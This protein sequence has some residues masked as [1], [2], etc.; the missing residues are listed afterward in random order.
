MK[1]LNSVITFLILAIIGTISLCFVTTASAQP[2]A[3]PWDVN[4]DGVVDIKDLVFVGSHF[5]D[6][7]IT[8][9]DVNGDGLA[10][11]A[12]LI[13]VGVH[14]GEEYKPTKTT[15]NVAADAGETVEMADGAAVDIPPMALSQN[16]SVTI[17]VETDPGIPTEISP[18]KRA[19]G[20]IY[21]IDVGD[22]A[23]HEAIT[24]TLPYDPSRVPTG[25]S[26]E[27]LCLAYWDGNRWVAQESSV[28]TETHEIMAQTN[29]LSGWG[30]WLWSRLNRPKIE[31]F[32]SE[33]EEYSS[34]NRETNGS[35]KEDLTFRAE[36]A[37]GHGIQSA[38][39]QIGLRTYGTLGAAGIS[40]ICLAFGPVPPE[41]TGPCKT[42]LEMSYQDGAYIYLLP[43]SK[44]DYIDANMMTGIDASVTATNTVGEST[45][46]DPIYVP[47]YAP[48]TGVTS[49]NL[50]SPRNNGEASPR[51]TLTWQFSDPESALRFRRVEVAVDSDYNV[52]SGWFRYEVAISNDLLVTSHTIEKDLSKGKT[53]YWA[54]R[55]TD[56]VWDHR[57]IVSLPHR[58]TVTTPPEI[59]LLEP[60]NNSAED[61]NPTFTWQISYVGSNELGYGLY[62]DDDRD[63]FTDPLFYKMVGAD[64]SFRYIDELPNG[65][66]YWGVKAFY[67]D[68]AGNVIPGTEAFSD[69]WSF[70]VETPILYVS[71]AYLGFDP[72]EST[73]TFQIRN[74]GG[75]TLRWEISLVPEWLNI[76][77]TAG[78]NDQVIA[79]TLDRSQIPAGTGKEDYFVI[80]AGSQYKEI[81]V[82]VNPTMPG[83]NEI[84]GNDGAPM[85]LIPAG[86]FQMSDHHGDGYSDERPV[87]AVYLD[88]FY[89]DKYEVTNAQFKKFVEANPEWSKDGID[90]K[91]HDGAY[92]RDWNGNN[93]PEGKGDHP[94]IWVSW[95]AA[96]AYAQWAGKRLPTEAEW[97]RAARGT[98]IG[99]GNY[100][101]YVWG[102]EWPPPEGAG[103]FYSQYIDGYHDDYPQTAPVGRFNPNGYGLHDM[104]GNVWEW[105]ADE[106]RSSYYSISPDVIHNPKGPGVPVT[107]RNNDFTNVNTARVI[108]GGGW[109]YYDWG[110]LRV[111]Y[112]NSDN[113]DGTYFGIG[114][115][116]AGL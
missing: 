101:R 102:D 2:E 13:L 82:S 16:T 68:S 64:T 71:V 60:A 96:A 63:P 84:I 51:P 43:L 44:L 69:I 100:K 26:E 19:V 85:V 81:S 54:V 30:G 29:H 74:D 46:S 94:V 34:S 98:F 20:K 106:Y 3:H 104:A 31:R 99:E 110:L 111:A 91:Y 4:G 109:H 113:P 70:T 6:S 92:L 116:C 86:E 80:K 83:P 39:I 42:D 95:Y 87:H 28:N 40:R 10:N 112:R 73:R 79:A 25:A 8:S 32:W 50:V 105:C 45:T 89:M 78:E 58:F 75:G 38:T 23:I 88:A 17:E 12:D 49:I 57:D 65:T 41:R 1:R 9:A 7:S 35:F 114:F 67:M 22:A 72:G 5:G 15:V 24:I 33:P 77:P 47:V 61:P 97:E 66:Y 107:F 108:R 52:W 115:R 53:Y 93:Y 55:L 36:I 62:V 48:N 14:F 76:Y 37:D 21:K 90:R 27:D 56:H 103:N 11:I 18:D 59:T